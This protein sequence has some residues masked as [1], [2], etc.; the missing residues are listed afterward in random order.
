MTTI[1]LPEFN[2]GAKVRRIKDGKRFVILSVTNWDVLLQP[3][4]PGRGHWVTHTGMRVKYE[5]VPT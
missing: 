5:G 1:P 4:D 3:E 2:K